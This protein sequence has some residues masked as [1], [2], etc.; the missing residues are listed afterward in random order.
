M[1]QEESEGETGVTEIAKSPL[2]ILI[3]QQSLTP[4][5]LSAVLDPKMMNLDEF[6]GD[7]VDSACNRKVLELRR[8]AN[9][10]FS[11]QESTALP[12]A[13]SECTTA[14]WM[15]RSPV[16]PILAG[17]FPG[18]LLPNLCAL[19]LSWTAFGTADV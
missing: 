7:T 9:T 13:K 19:E 12:L 4:S 10:H 3:L 2:R 14:R 8:M 17:R 6:P 5:V 16:L 1:F 18:Q 15:S 11:N